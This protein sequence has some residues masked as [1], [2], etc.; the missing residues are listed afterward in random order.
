MQLETFVETIPLKAAVRITGYTFTEVT[1]LLVFV[2]D[3]PFVGYGEAAGVYYRN[4]V[5]LAMADQVEALRPTIEAGIDR[6]ALQQLL[7]PG[8]AR[9]ALDCALWDLDAKRTGRPV[10]ELAALPPPKPIVTTYTL[11]ADT[12]AAMADVA[13]SIPDARALKL[14]LTGG[15]SDADRVRAVR[16][17]RPDVWLAVDANQGFSRAS[18]EAL[19][20]VFVD[21]DV[22][23]IE[24]PLPVGQ[25][26]DLIGLVSPI[27]IAADESVLSLADLGRISDF[28]DMI[29]IK[30]D[31]CGGLT[32]GLAMATEARRLGL[33]V[34]VGNMA[35]TSLAMAPAFL[36]GQ[37]CEVVDLDGPLALAADRTPAAVYTHGRIWC[38]EAVW[39]GTIRNACR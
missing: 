18:L 4:D 5:P 38:P 30:L 6:Q 22:K 20:P 24:Q 10:W 12:A 34:M 35:G 9:N 8:G 11:G 23:L 29:N 7:P 26:S 27:P 25:E 15:M 19:L 36:L 2:R 32:E 31:K 39:G 21:A 17:A 14:K 13:R 3:G 37:L 1:A 28:F 33:K 16:A